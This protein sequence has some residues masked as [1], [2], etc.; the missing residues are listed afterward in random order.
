MWKKHLERDDSII[1]GEEVNLVFVFSWIQ[2]QKLTL[3]FFPALDRSFLRSAAE[4]TALL[5]LFALLQHV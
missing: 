4:F 1:V 5:G 3:H 2:K